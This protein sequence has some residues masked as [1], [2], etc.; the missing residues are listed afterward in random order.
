MS[1]AALLAHTTGH[2][3]SVEAL[4]EDLAG[5]PGSSFMLPHD[6][7][8][9]TA[10]ILKRYCPEYL[11]A[12]LAAADACCRNELSLLGRTFRFPHGIDWHQDP[13]TG[14]R[15]PLVHRS[16]VD[17]HLGSNRPVDLI[18][19]WELN[20]H[21]HFVTLG[22]AFWLTGRAALRGC[23]QL[24]GPEL[25]RYQSDSTRRQLVLWPGSVHSNHCLDC[26]VP[27][28]S[29]LTAI[30]SNNREGLPEEPLAA[31]RFPERPPSD[32]QNGRWGTKQSHDGGADR[33]DARGCRVPR[34]SKLGSLA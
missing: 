24:P 29:Q 9:E 6:S 2:W 13:V 28:L 31:G 5:R 20:R 34:I 27:V 16:R 32:Q 15:W 22:I 17:R 10:A 3:P 26:G 21:Q 14:W 18:V 30:P 33:L 23:L 12:V 1:D 7:P 25:D 11:P 4:L 8:D 19:F